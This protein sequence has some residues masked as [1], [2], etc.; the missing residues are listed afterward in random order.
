MQIANAFLLSEEILKQ[1]LKEFEAFRKLKPEN[2]GS[3]E[4][5]RQNL[6]G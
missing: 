4:Q 5:M 1:Q 3:T 6:R 2:G